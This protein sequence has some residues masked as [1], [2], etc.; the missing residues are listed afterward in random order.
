MVD[1]ETEVVLAAP[2]YH[3]DE[4]DADTMVD[5]VMEAQTNLSEAGIDVEI[6]EAAADKGYHATDT[7]ELADCAEHPHVHP[8]AEAEREAELAGRA[9]GEASGGHQQSASHARRTEQAA[10]A[11]AERTG[12]TELRPCVRHGRCPA[13]LACVGS[14]RFKSV[15]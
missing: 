3:A 4:G 13:E 6:E 2:I 5:S 9:G 15:T 12:G 7:L 8:R 11:S 14:R 10:A 1:L